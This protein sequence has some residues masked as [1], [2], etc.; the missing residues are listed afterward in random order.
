MKVSCQL[1][2]SCSESDQFQQEITKLKEEN[3]KSEKRYEKANSDH[4]ALKEKFEN[5]KKA[6]DQQ[7]DII[8]NLKAEN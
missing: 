4:Q 8:E 2:D 6:R 1:Q 7:T 5:E 3:T